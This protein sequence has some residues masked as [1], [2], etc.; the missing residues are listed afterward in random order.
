[1]MDIAGSTVLKGMSK[2]ITDKFGG[3]ITVAEAGGSM[4]LLVEKMAVRDLLL[5]LKSYE[6][7]P[8]TM[9]TDLFG[10]DRYGQD[11]RFEVVYL[12]NS[13]SATLRIIVRTRVADGESTPTASDIFA[14]ANWLEREAYDMFGL[15][16]DG[17]PNLTRILTVDDFDGHPLRKDFP[18]QG[19]GF[20]RPFAVDLGEETT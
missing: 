4:D 15:R 6:E 16:F 12:L 8:F 20:D 10:V 11:P 7:A 5:F 13:L 17:H 14:T 2:R 1:V 3:A 9:L 19:Y 18:T